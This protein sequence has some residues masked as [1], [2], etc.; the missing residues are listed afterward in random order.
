MEHLKLSLPL[1]LS[2]WGLIA[3]LWQKTKGSLHLLCILIGAF[4]KMVTMVKKLPLLGVILILIF[5]QLRQPI[6][7]LR[8]LRT[9]VSRHTC[10]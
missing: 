3:A 6:E 8:G 7:L 9:F 5:A 2:F 4:K 10:L 1:T